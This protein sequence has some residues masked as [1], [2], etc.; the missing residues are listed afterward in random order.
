MARPREGYSYLHN[1]LRYPV[2]RLRLR[3]VFRGSLCCSIPAWRS[4]SW[5]V[6]WLASDSYYPLTVYVTPARNASRHLVLPVSLV[7]EG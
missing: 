6:S 3:S 4:R 7:H 5:Y 1:D 2:H